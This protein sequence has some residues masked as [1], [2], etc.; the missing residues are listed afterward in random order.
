MKAGMLAGRIP[1]PSAFRAGEKPDVFRRSM[2]HKGART[3]FRRDPQVTRQGQLFKAQTV[4]V[5][6][7]SDSKHAPARKASSPYSSFGVL[8][9]HG[10]VLYRA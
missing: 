9:L 1:Q 7:R 4:S 10:H 2:E 5:S 8:R 6:S 3:I